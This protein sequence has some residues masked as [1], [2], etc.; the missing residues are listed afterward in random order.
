[1]NKKKEKKDGREMKMKI[2]FLRIKKDIK[3]RTKAAST[4]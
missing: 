2:R 3:W 4:K 1:M